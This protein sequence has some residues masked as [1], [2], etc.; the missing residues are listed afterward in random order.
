MQ[1]FIFPLVLLLV[2]LSLASCDKD[3]TSDRYKYLTGSVWVSDSL[4]V[5]GQDASVPGGLLENFRG[6]A[7]FNKDGSGTF[8]NY[9]GTW[10]FAQ[11]ETELVIQSD[12]LPY[13]L[14]LSTQ[15]KELTAQSL[16]ITTSVPDLQNLANPPM[17]VRLTF[18]SK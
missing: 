9:Q 7:R 17:Q 3:D 2:V 14:P 16:K 11:E 6:E 5:N 1:R 12:S 13:G 15:I 18:N 8:G 4:L 10:R